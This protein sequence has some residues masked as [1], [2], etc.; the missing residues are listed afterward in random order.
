MKPSPDPLDLG[1]LS[2][3]GFGPEGPLMR[4]SKLLLDVNFLGTLLAEF[5]RELGPEAASATFFRI[6]VLLGLRDAQRALQGSFVA[7]HAPPG[8]L[9]AATA[10]LAMR[11]GSRASGC[12]VGSLEVAGSWPERLEAEARLSKLGTSPRPSCAL[13]SG[14]TSG[15]LS[16]ILETDVVAQE[17]SCAARGDES[18]SFL[19]CEVEGWQRAGD[20]EAL[21]CAEQVDFPTF[22][23]LA[24]RYFLPPAVE[25]ESGACV[26]DAGD[27]DA[28][29]PVVHVWGPV[30]VLPFLGADIA[31]QTV[32][33]L[34]RDPSVEQVRVVVV[35]LRDAPVDDGFEGAALE[36]VLR[37]ISGWGAEAILTGV[38]PLSE[39]LVA[40]LEAEHL[41]VRKAVSEAI[42]AAFQIAEAQRFLV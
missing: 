19:A 30:M 23:A 35:D 42:A 14:Y 41:V 32:D 5:E 29:A 20:A 21:R 33:V 26:R 34:A 39:P 12:P 25:G 16:G 40:D 3:L 27:F 8:A 13:S 1:A 38:S 15:W 11:L 22:R 31:M 9:P 24:A 18:C 36:Q 10:P 6:G 37:R 28:G 17:Q 7:L 4:E 2:A